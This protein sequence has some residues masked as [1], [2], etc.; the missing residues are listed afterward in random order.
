MSNSGDPR[1]R[2]EAEARLLQL[3]EEIDQLR[4]DLG[5]K[6]DEAAE[7]MQ[8]VSSLHATSSEDDSRAD[9]QDAL[10]PQAHRHRAAPPI[11]I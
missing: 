1:A 8:R 9:S 4:I 3:T 11:A 2:P 10:E 5:R 7:L 6:I